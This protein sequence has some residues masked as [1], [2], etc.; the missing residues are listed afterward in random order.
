MQGVRAFPLPRI[1]SRVTART[2]ARRGLHL[3]VKMSGMWEV[4]SA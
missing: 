1:H 2:P 3:G 4:G